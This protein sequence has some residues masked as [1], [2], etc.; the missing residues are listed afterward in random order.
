LNRRLSQT[1]CRFVL[2]FDS[3]SY[4]IRFFGNDSKPNSLAKQALKF[5][6]AKYINKILIKYGFK[7]LNPAKTLIDSKTNLEPNKERAKT[8]EIHYFQ[9]FISY[10][11]FLALACRP[12]IT[13]V[14]IKLARFAS[15]PSQ[16]H[17]QAIKR[18]FRYLKNN[19]PR[20]YLFFSL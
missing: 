19:Y 4:S 12:D 2:I 5:Y 15:N 11:L 7:N 10:L 16:N 8:S 14:I 17:V 3:K 1:V 6:Q 13:F 18:I 9:I 20:Y